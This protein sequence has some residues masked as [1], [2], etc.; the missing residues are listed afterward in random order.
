M[1]DIILQKL[2]NAFNIDTNNLSTNKDLAYELLSASIAFNRSPY[3]IKENGW[4]IK[5]IGSRIT[6]NSQDGK[7]DAFNVGITNESILIELI[8]SKNTSSVSTNDIDN[9]FTSIKNYI[10]DL[11]NSLPTSHQSLEKIRILINDYLDK[12]P[13]FSVKYKIYISA[14][15]FN[16]SLLQNIQIIFNSTFLRHEAELKCIDNSFIE[17]EVLSIQNKITNENYNTVKATISFEQN[18]ELRDEEQSKIL[19]GIVNANEVFKMIDE[20]FKAN[21]D[22][23]RLFSSNVRGFLG[24]SPVNELIKNTILNKPK[25]FLSLNNGA[26]ILCDRIEPR[27][28]NAFVITNPNIINGQQ[29]MASIYK[30]AKRNQPL[31]KVNLQV[32]IIE[33]SEHH[34]YNAQNEISRSS[35]QANKIDDIDLLANK[36]LIKKLRSFFLGERIIFKHQTRR[37]FK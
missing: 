23:T 4:N 7:I 2:V 12:Y 1:I 36:P 34:R 32:K 22:L 10:M 19:I 8:Q 11:N 15:S 35:N 3:Y 13:N 24:S 30:Y 21:Y 17:N 6:N 28:S 31:N 29:T 5:E 27:A 37:Y 33:L 14:N 26:V 16:A 18:A 9:Y 25:T 20:E